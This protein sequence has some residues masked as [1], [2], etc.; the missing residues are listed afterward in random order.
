MNQLFSIQKDDAWKIVRIFGFTFR[1]ARKKKLRFIYRK[2][3]RHAVLRRDGISLIGGFHAASG[4]GQSARDFHARLS[5]SGIPFDL[6]E[7]N[8]KEKCFNTVQYPHFFCKVTVST[9]FRWPDPRYCNIPVLVWEFDRGMTEARPYLFHGNQG[10]IALSAFNAEYFRKVVPEGMPVWQV[11]PPLSVQKPPEISRKKVRAKW[12]I[13]KDDFCLFYNFS[14]SSSYFRKNPEGLLKAF[15][16]AFAGR[17]GVKLIL[18]TTGQKHAPAMQQRMLGLIQRLGISSQV[19]VIDH[20]LSRE[21]ML[22]LMMASDGYISLHRGEGV[23]LGMLEA[24]AL[25]RPV[26]ATSFGGNTDFTRIGTAKLIGYQM[27]PPA[28][29]DQPDYRFVDQWPEPDIK[30]AA[31]AMQ[32]LRDQPESAVRLG[33]AG[34]AFIHDYLHIDHFREDMEKVMQDCASMRHP[35][36][37]VKN[38]G[39]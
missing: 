31:S 25:G 36:R 28:E 39:M 7:S 11:R 15:A 34:Q 13:E 21:E 2:I 14:Y 30:A 6:M 22:V 19:R 23:G 37:E 24:M 16:S 3:P 33:L 29:N 27:V 4:E 35:F 8:P 12:E 26:I 5:Q 20:F 38:D 18:K 32:E 10:V 1:I 9:S 17:G